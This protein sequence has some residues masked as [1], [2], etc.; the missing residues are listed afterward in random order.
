MEIIRQSDFDEVIKYLED[1]G[2]FN[3]KDT[4]KNLGAY[5]YYYF[6]RITEDEFWSLVFL[7]ITE[8]LQIAPKDHDR[9]LRAVAERAVMLGNIRLSV[10]WDL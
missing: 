1:L 4:Q 7:Q 6:V 10:N 3:Y 2:S 8:V 5:S 9:R